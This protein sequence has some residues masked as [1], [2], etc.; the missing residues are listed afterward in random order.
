MFAPVKWADGMAERAGDLSKLFT[1]GAKKVEDR[2]MTAFW[3]RPH[4]AAMFEQ[5]VELR[6]GHK[7]L[8][9]QG[10]W[11]PRLGLLLEDL[12]TYGAKD[13]S[14]ED[15]LLDFLEKA[16]LYQGLLGL[17]GVDGTIAVKP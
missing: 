7:A 13:P 4:S 11:E 3:A 8:S 6:K 12:K 14:A 5:C 1:G 16:R 15:H 10:A 17:S 2:P 9:A